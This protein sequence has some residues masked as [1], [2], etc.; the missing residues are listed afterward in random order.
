MFVDMNPALSG[1]M[2][3]EARNQGVSSVV[4]AP[5]LQGM[6]LLC[7]FQLSG[8]PAA[9]GLRLHCSGL[10]LHPHITSSPASLMLHP[11]FFF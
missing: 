10:C 5:K 11:F 7:L 9:L 6:I 1:F 4:L 2:V 8:A 3:L